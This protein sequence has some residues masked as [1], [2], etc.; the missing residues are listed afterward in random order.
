MASGKKNYF[1]HS[2]FARND[3]FL[4]NL[5][6]EMGYQGYFLWFSLLEVCGEIASDSYPEHF[7]IHNARLLRSLRC[8][9][10]KLDSFLT[11][12][13]LESRLSHTRV[14]NNHIIQIH[15]FRKY[16]GKYDNLKESNTP[17]KRKEKEIKE[18]EII[19]SEPKK[20]LPEKDSQEIL[21]IAS[22]LSFLFSSSPHIQQWLNAGIHETHMML[23]KKYSHHELVELIEAAYVWALPKQIRAETWLYTFVSNKKTSAFNPNQGKAT[24][25][26]QMNTVALTDENPTG[27]PYKAQRLAKEKGGV[28]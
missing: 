6:D 26:N 10:D 11:L 22:P 2:F 5:V 21:K 1:R 20:N 14:E 24:F 27:N 13:R 18:K 4:I 9:Q 15:N 17:N 28:A 16:L 25:K 8:R 19:I 3:D 7:K 12:A 23:V